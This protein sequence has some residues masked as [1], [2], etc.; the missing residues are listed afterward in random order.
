[1]SDSSAPRTEHLPTPEKMEEASQLWLLAQ[2]AL[3]QGLE[4]EA[5]ELARLFERDDHRL[6]S[7]SL[8]RLAAVARE[9]D[10]PRAAIWCEEEVHVRS[11]AAP[12]LKRRLLKLLGTADEEAR[13]R[14]HTPRERKVIGMVHGPAPSR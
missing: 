14:D 13:V 6:S 2:A 1:M 5:L 9:S 7:R 12:S 4:R 8:G 10:L 3:A 11:Y